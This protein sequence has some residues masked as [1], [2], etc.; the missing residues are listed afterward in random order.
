MKFV[1]I[2]ILLISILDAKCELDSLI[3][4]YNGLIQSK[5][6]LLSQTTRS[7]ELNLLIP[8]CKTIRKHEVNWGSDPKSSKRETLTGRMFLMR[9]RVYPDTL[10]F[11]NNMT[12]GDDWMVG[13]GTIQREYPFYFI[14]G[15]SLTLVIKMKLNLGN[16]KSVDVEM[17]KLSEHLKLFNTHHALLKLVSQS[18]HSFEYNVVKISD[19]P[20]NEIPTSLRLPVIWTDGEVIVLNIPKIEPP[21]YTKFGFSAESAI[22]GIPFDDPRPFKRFQSKIKV[23]DDMLREFPWVLDSTKAINARHKEN[24]FLGGGTP[25]N[26]SDTTKSK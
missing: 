12:Q 10:L 11:L 20:S 1:L 23:Y 14:D 21:I 5:Q 19:A 24:Q 7:K 25:L 9:Y 22:G 6:T 16:H 18:P 26:I 8:D 17:M 4:H 2:I 3:T 13:F 15:R